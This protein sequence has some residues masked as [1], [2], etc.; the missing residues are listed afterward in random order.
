MTILLSA[1]AAGWADTAD[2]DALAGDINTGKIAYSNAIRRVG[3]AL[4]KPLPE[5]NGV[6]LEY[7]NP[8]GAASS[9]Y[10]PVDGAGVIVESLVPTIIT[11]GGWELDANG[12]AWDS[13]S[14]S[15]FAKDTTVGFPAY[16]TARKW[17]VWGKTKDAS[18]TTGSGFR[19][20]FNYQDSSN[21]WYAR[22]NWNGTAY[23]WQIR[24]YVAS[25]D[26][27]RA[28][29]TISTA[30]TV[31]SHFHMT[32]YEQGDDLILQAVMWEIDTPANDDAVSCQYNIASRPLK[33]ETMFNLQLWSTT[34]DEFLI[35]G[36]R[37][38]DLL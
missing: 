26:T 13:T 36:F 17:E 6:L 28:A 9:A 29:A 38:S 32:L 5:V 7:V 18:L 4:I 11:T 33:T 8:T 3:I 16:T 2:G 21:Y 1:L 14:F 35:R 24:E 37:V 22:V 31:P 25:V 23:Y 19:L 27:F 12:Y 10:N 34:D 20:I 15:T 30:V